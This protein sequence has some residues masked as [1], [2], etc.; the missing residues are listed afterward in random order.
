M[1]ASNPMGIDKEQAFG[2]AEIEMEHKVELFNRLTQTCFKKCFEKRYKDSELNMGEISCIDRCV[3][4]YWQVNN[5]I[6]QLL[7]GG[8]R[9]SM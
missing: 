2:M 6:G 8:G 7:A 5:L 1:A 9:P 3:F 4:K